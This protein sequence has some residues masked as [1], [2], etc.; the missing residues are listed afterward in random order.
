[1]PACL[2]ANSKFNKRGDVIGNK[3]FI[4]KTP[5]ALRDVRALPAS[6]STYFVGSPNRAYTVYF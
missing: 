1:M 6:Q 5:N 3:L 2:T 4:F